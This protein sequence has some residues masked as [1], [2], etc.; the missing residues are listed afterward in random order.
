VGGRDASKY[1]FVSPI[2]KRFVYFVVDIPDYLLQ[3]SYFH[4]P[5]VEF[6]IGCEL[7]TLN[8]SLELVR[9]TKESLRLKSLGWFT[10]IAR[11]LISIAASFGTTRGALM[12]EVSGLK[13]GNST[14]V[15]AS[16]FAAQRGEVIP[17]LLPSI[18]AQT[19]LQGEI[20]RAGIIRLSDWLRIDQLAA[21][22]AK[23]NINL[24]IKSPGSEIWIDEK[25]V[26]QEE[27]SPICDQS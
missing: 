1:A 13:N 24:A 14:A 12:V 10:P 8:R 27:S 25:I 3:P 18:A 21:E 5:T 7:D 6:K 20:Q 4:T 23:R 17:A 19:I 15:A 22:L 16:I 9:W 2:G 11:V 26:S